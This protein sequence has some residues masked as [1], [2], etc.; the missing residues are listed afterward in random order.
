VSRPP[1]FPSAAPVQMSAPP[2]A[3]A[4]AVADTRL[5]VAPEKFGK[6]RGIL[7]FV[8]IGIVGGLLA[9]V[10]VL[11][12]GLDARHPVP[13]PP[14]RKVETSRTAA[15]P[16]AP[17]Q[18]DEIEKTPPADPY[19]PPSA[20]AEIQAPIPS[21]KGDFFEL[22]ASGA[23]SARAEVF[24]KSSAEKALTA[25][26]ARA[27]NC[28]KVGEPPGMASVAV[29]FEPSGQISDVRVIG[30]PYADTPTAQ[31]ISSRFLGVRIHGFKG[32]PQTLVKNF[33]LY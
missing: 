24:D 17:K 26:A 10:W 15:L 5:S 6:K 16:P 14:D 11:S 8:V 1:P 31:C 3:Q 22:F 21:A 25:L 9:L 29:K 7:G 12:R 30:K 28:R 32:E 19:A 23:E 27:A 33:M 18:E 13:A 2:E 20:S 4:V